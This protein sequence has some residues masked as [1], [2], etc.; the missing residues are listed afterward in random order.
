[1]QLN[2]IKKIIINFIVI[3]MDSRIVVFKVDISI[4]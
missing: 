2:T 3:S 4:T 1:V